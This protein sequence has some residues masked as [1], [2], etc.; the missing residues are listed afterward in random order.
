VSQNREII[1]LIGR[2][3]QIFTNLLSRSQILQEDLVKYQ[4]QNL[5]R[6]Q[7]HQYQF[8]HQPQLKAGQKPLKFSS[9]KMLV[10]GMPTTK[11]MKMTRRVFQP[12]HSHTN[13][14][15]ILPLFRILQ[16]VPNRIIMKLLINRMVSSKKRLRANMLMTL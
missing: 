12:R 13:F 8:N 4:Y 11:E 5:Q 9:Q 1:L 16:R 2:H 10:N 7:I 3:N 15:K 6:T 14:M